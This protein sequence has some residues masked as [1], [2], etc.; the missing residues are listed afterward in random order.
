[1]KLDSDRSWIQQIYQIFLDG[2][3]AGAEPAAGRFQ[4][5]D[6]DFQTLD[7][8][9]KKQRSHFLSNTLMYKHKHN[10]K[11]VKENFYKP[12]NVLPGK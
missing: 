1:M 12:E 6:Q 5:E 7:S 4:E 8:L 9:I 10:F 11:N 2:P 3:L